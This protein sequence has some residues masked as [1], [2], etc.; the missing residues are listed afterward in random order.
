MDKQTLLQMLVDW[1][2][3]V[4]PEFE[5]ALLGISHC[6]TPKAVYDIDTIIAILIERDGMTQEDAIEHFDYNIAG[7]YV[8]KST[9]VFVWYK[10]LDLDSI[11]NN[12]KKQ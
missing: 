2:C 6:S 5:D 10:D 11:V 12:N 7:S 4:A 8:G 1:K 9:P 3:I